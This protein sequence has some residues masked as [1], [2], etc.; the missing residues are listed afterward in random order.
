MPLVSEHCRREW[1]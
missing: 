1:I